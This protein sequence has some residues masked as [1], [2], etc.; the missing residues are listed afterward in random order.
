MFT[1]ESLLLLLVNGQMYAF[2]FMHLVM[3]LDRSLKCKSARL[4]R[5]ADAYQQISGAPGPSGG[6]MQAIQVLCTCRKHGNMVAWVASASLH[7]SAPTSAAKART[8]CRASCILTAFELPIITCY[9]GLDMLQ[10]DGKWKHDALMPALVAT[11]RSSWTSR[12]NHFGSRCCNFRQLCRHLL[13][14]NHDMTE[15]PR[16]ISH[17]ISFPRSESSTASRVSCC[18]QYCDAFWSFSFC[19]MC[20]TTNTTIQNHESNPIFVPSFLSLIRSL[21]PVVQSELPAAPSDSS[22]LFNS[23]N[24]NV[25]TTKNP[26]T[27]HSKTRNNMT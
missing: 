15:L 22:S 8:A 23:V 2:L 9:N 12:G 1:N 7:S 13:V 20:N 19:K 26:L 18:Q 17:P 25:K 11:S 16:S 3:S 10:H 24:G 4:T 27:M 21:G 6:A 5:S 14:P